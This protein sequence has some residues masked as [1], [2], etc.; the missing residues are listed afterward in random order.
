M[1]F[2]IG[3]VGSGTTN[4]ELILMLSEKDIFLLHLITIDM[5]DNASIFKKL[6]SYEYKWKSRVLT[7]L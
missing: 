4:V 1:F 5:M 2:E 6:R 7:N 3:D